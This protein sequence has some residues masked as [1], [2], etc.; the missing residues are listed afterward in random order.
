VGLKENAVGIARGNRFY[1]SAVPKD[2]RDTIDH[3]EEKIIDGSIQ[4]RS[5]FGM[6]QEEI[7]ELFRSV[8]PAAVN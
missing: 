1:L 2:I 6:T 5:A 7:E 8:S 4:V 3:L